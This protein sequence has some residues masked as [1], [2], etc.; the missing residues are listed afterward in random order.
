[1]TFLTAQ[2]FKR[3]ITVPACLPQTELYRGQ[4]LVVA[5]WQLQ[6]GQ[7]I[8][9]RSLSLT[10]LRVLNPGPVPTYANTALGAASVGFYLDGALTSPLALASVRTVGTATANPFAV[11]TVRTPGRYT[12]TVANNTHNLDLAVCVT[13]GFRVYT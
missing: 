9:L 8:L 3:V 2:Q 13:G 4:S 6:H 5:T 1:M 10:V 7:K 11:C 12:V